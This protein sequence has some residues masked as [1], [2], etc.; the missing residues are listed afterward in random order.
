MHHRSAAHQLD[1]IGWHI[2]RELQENARIPF[3]ELGRRVGLS[4]PA[5]AERVRNMEDSG[6]IRGYRT[7]VDPGACGFN[8]LAYIR[9]NVAGDKLQHFVEL[10]K[11]RPEIL[12]C[13]RVTG[14]ESF[15]VKMA[16]SDMNHLETTIDSLMPYV[17]TTTSMIL[18]SAITWGP[19]RPRAISEESVVPGV[20]L[21]T[22]ATNNNR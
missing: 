19:V 14:A 8:V 3:A 17:A 13:H 1:Q 20:N 2:L 12:E 21:P 10:A 7:E 16:V 4:T 11:T 18:S 9:V 22:K 5:V 15:I 6:I